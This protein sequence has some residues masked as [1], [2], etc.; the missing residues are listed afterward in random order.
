MAKVLSINISEKKGIA[1]TPIPEGEFKEDYGLV[2]DAHA[3]GGIRQ[4]SLLAVE[5]RRKIEN[6]PKI[7]L[8][9]KNGDFGE[10]ITT[11]GII[12]HTLPIGTRLKIGE[13]VL[14]VSKIG[15]ECHAPCAIK[16]KVGICVM[17][18]EGIFAV[19]RKGGRIRVG[20]S[21]EIIEEVADE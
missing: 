2:G 1:K 5:S 18:N 9:L 21:I 13:V 10:N 14:E 15:K 16:K 11:E 3:G 6:H 7:K 12:L 8:C 20:D 17:P 19:V 4:V